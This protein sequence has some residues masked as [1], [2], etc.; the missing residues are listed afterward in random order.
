[1][2]E[3]AL[4]K[5]DSCLTMR[6]IKEIAKAMGVKEKSIYFYGTPTYKKRTSE[7]K[8]MRLIKIS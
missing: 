8:G 1:M 4:Y 7:N 5:G 3:Y 2:K 6:T